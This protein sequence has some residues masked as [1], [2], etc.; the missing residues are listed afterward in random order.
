M[1]VR[2]MVSNDNPDAQPPLQSGGGGGTFEDMSIVDAKVAAA[3]ARTDT[4]FAGLKGSLDLMNERLDN[5]QA[6]T[7][8]VR[9]NIWLAAATALGLG[10]AAMAF[11]SS[12][13]GNGVMVTTAAVRD[14]ADAKRIA[15]ENANEVRALRNELG[16]FIQA[17]QHERP[18]PQ[19]APNDPRNFQFLPVPQQ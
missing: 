2:L 10:I 14:A 12:Q 5:I 7:N 6:A 16:A 3:E 9:L 11:G 17:I 1:P 13:F 8:G 15:Q 18:Q 4:K 19:L